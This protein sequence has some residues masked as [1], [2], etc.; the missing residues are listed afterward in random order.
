MAGKSEREQ[1]G[2]LEGTFSRPNRFRKESLQFRRSHR[3]WYTAGAAGSASCSSIWR[4]SSIYSSEKVAPNS[5]HVSHSPP[6]FASEFLYLG[7][8][9]ANSASLLPVSNIQGL[10]CAATSGSKSNF[11][12]EYEWCRLL[13]NCFVLNQQVGEHYWLLLILLL[14]LTYLQ[15][16][17]YATITKLL[18][19]I[20][21]LID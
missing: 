7:I 9:L 1:A 8:N 17:I 21:L 19:M 16:R 10:T 3:F 2:L 6:N 20:A 4:F 12:L 15:T 13:Q 11:F 14:F 5:S 18:L